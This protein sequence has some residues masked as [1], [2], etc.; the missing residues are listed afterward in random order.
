MCLMG[1]V[2]PFT[3][4]TM[5]TVFYRSTDTKVEEEDAESAGLAHPYRKSTIACLGM[6]G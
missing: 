5:R 6:D 4:H 2:T 1:R 3:G